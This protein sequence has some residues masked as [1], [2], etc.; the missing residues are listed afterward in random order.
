MGGRK[1]P[2]DP[3]K[4]VCKISTDEFRANINKYNSKVSSDKKIVLQS[5]PTKWI[6]IISHDGALGS[7]LG[8]ISKIKIGNQTMSGDYFRRNIMGANILRSHCFSYKFVTE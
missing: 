3:G 5:D 7:N 1:S 6:T 8:Y 2:E 4:R